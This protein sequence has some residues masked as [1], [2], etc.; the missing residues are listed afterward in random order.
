MSNPNGFWVLTMF[1]FLALAGRSQVNSPYSRFGIGDLYNSRNVH[2]K[3]MGGLASPIRD[4]QSVNFINPASYSGIGF[5]T[6]DVGIEAE[7]RALVNEAKTERFESSNMIF[8]YVAMGVPLLK[9]KKKE[10]TLWGM[11]FGIRPL[12]RIRYDIISGDRTPG[13]DSTLTEF[14]GNGGLY[15]AFLGTGFRVGGLS[16]G[17]NAGYIFGQKDL[18][19]YRSFV[20]DSVPYYTAGFTQRTSINSFA[21]DAGLQYEVKLSKNTS[22]RLGATGYLGGDVRAER[23]RIA[24]TIFFNS[25]GA[26]DSIDVVSRQTT[27]GNYS[28]PAGYSVGL[29]LE[30]SNKYMVG[31][32]YETSKWSEL[33]NFG[34]NAMMGDVTMLRVGAQLIPDVM[35]VRSYFKQVAY[36]VGFFSGKDYV[37]IDGKQLP[38]W[39]FTLGAGLPIRRYNVYSTQF[40]TIN[41]SFEYGRRGGVEN[42]Y[43]ERYFRLNFG[44]ALSDVW[45]IKRQYD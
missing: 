2:S 14:Q 11:A 7:F 15:R 26:V 16:L 29:A 19:T 20:N 43:F 41:F 17:V 31:A 34:A 23:E 5:V 40:N 30:R 4:I 38:S 8:N 10:N 9:D 39:G 13:I 35:S 36:R 44:L 42:P 27:K 25:F 24:Q 37:I 32:E 6:F 28:L 21:A 33:T 12:S 18:S 22:L 3:A 1:L 45:F